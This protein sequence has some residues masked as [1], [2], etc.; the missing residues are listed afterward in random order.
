MVVDNWQ[1]F[2]VV[3]NSTFAWFSVSNATI[4][5]AGSPDTSS[6]TCATQGTSLGSF[7][8]TP[9]LHAEIDGAIALSDSKGHVYGEN[10]AHTQQFLLDDQND[11]S[12]T[13][14][15]A[16]IDLTISYSGNLS[17]NSE[18]LAAWQALTTTGYVVTFTDTTDYTADNTTL[19][20]ALVALAATNAKLKGA[21]FGLKVK[22]SAAPTRHASN[23]TWENEGTGTHAANTKAINNIDLSSPGTFSA[24][25]G[26]AG[27][28]TSSV[29]VESAAT[30]YIGIVGING[31]PQ[32]SDDAYSCSFAV[33]GGGI[34]VPNNP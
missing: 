34:P 32:T 26:S 30:F 6:L 2:F 22:T 29:T 14:K 20:E 9:V 13:Y 31:V 33:S 7:T 5:A 17:T 10:A 15:T 1:P 19:D 4:N 16:V 18:V 28:Y 3:S 12:T 8:I 11:V 27:S 25:S 21:D 23:N 24:P